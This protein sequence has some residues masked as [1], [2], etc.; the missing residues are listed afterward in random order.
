MAMNINQ[1]HSA[2][3]SSTFIKLQILTFLGFLS[4]FELKM[5]V[6]DEVCAYLIIQSAV[7]FPA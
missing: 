3:L 1:Q 6:F 7:V 4:I 2:T 5:R